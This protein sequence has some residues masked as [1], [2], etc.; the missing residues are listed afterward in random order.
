M[1]VQM[2]WSLNT[3]KPSSHDRDGNSVLM[4]CSDNGIGGYARFVYLSAMFAGILSFFSWVFQERVLQCIRVRFL[5]SCNWWLGSCLHGN[6]AWVV[7]MTSIAVLV[8]W[9]F[10]SASCF[11]CECRLAPV[12]DP[13][14]PRAAHAATAVGTM[15][16]IQV[17]LLLSQ[18][19]TNI[20][21]L[22]L[23]L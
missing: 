16:V 19:W 9:H 23:L 10:D 12:G 14:S 6:Y 17:H 3:S 5:G 8:Y 18:V 21:G 20:I 7:L 13:P 11:A 15:V 1:F 2:V 22:K 4:V